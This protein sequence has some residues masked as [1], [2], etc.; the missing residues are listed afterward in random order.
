MRVEVVSIG[1]KLLMSDILD[2]YTAY[3]THSLRELHVHLTCKVTVGND[4]PMITDVLR[5]ALSRADIVIA[6]GGQ[7]NGNASIT[8]QAIAEATEQEV[9]ARSPGIS[10]A[11]ELGGAKARSPGLLIEAEN[12]TLIY[13]PGNRREQD[14]QYQ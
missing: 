3:I 1:T 14:S 6:I 5:V 8:H 10:G 9:L 4:M 11:V 7:E 2:T 13:L 12:S